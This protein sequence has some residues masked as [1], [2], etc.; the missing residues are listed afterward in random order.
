MEDD[1][2]ASPTS[3]DVFEEAVKRLALRFPREVLG[4][5]CGLDVEGM[6]ITHVPPEDFGPLPPPGLVFCLREPSSDTTDKV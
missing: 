6:E 5:L 1:S 3:A 4:K 2:Q